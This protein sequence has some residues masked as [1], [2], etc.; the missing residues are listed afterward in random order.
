[1]K[2]LHIKLD[3]SSRAQSCLIVPNR[4]IFVNKFARQSIASNHYHFSRDSLLGG[5]KPLV[6]ESSLGFEIGAQRRRY[7]AQINPPACPIFRFP[8]NCLLTGD[9][10]IANVRPVNIGPAG[11]Q[12][13]WLTGRPPFSQERG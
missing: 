12:W 2:H 5:P 13:L 6:V 4:V 11:R 1:M 10:A 8:R 7:I 9:A 3:F